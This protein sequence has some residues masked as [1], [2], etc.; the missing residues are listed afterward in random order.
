MTKCIVV[1]FLV[2]V[3]MSYDEPNVHFS[4]TFACHMILWNESYII[5]FWSIQ[6][7]KYVICNIMSFDKKFE[8]I[9]L[10]CISISNLSMN[11]KFS[12]NYI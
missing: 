6:I 1:S 9:S 4:F 12:N 10:I 2:W 3:V 8:K 5:N 11:R 7:N